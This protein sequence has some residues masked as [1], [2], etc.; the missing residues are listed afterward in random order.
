MNKMKGR[1]ASGILTASLLFAALV[2]TG[3]CGSIKAKAAPQ[4]NYKE[5][6]TNGIEGNGVTIHN[7]TWD[8]SEQC[9]V[10]NGDRSYIE[11]AN[12]LTKANANTGFS[13]EFEA[14]VSSAN[15]ADGTTFYRESGAT[16]S[17][18]GWQ[19]L[20]DL[21][22][23]T[24]N[25]YCFIN[26]GTSAPFR[27]AYTINGSAGEQRIDTPNGSAYY[28]AWH[29]Y[30]LVVAP[31][32][33]T[34]FYIDDNKVCSA[35]ANANT[36][37]VLNEL[38]SYNRCYIGTS[39]FEAINSNSDGFFIGKIK[40]FTFYP[41]TI[42]ATT[43][44]SG[45][46]LYT[47]AYEVNGGNRVQATSVSKLPNPLPTPTREDSQFLGWYTDKACTVEA[48]PGTELTK[49]T[50]L[51]AK[52]KINLS[53]KQDTTANYWPTYIIN[54][55]FEKQ[56]NMAGIGIPNGTDCGWNTTETVSNFFE[57]SNSGKSTYNPE[58]LT[59]G[60]NF[61]E[62]NPTHAVTLYQD[63]TTHGG[64]VIKWT[65]KHAPRTNLGG[66]PQQ[67]EVIIGNPKRNNGNIVYP[68][69][70][71]ANIQINVED[72]ATSKATYDY[73]NGK[74]IITGDAARANLQDLAALNLTEASGWKTAKGIY[75]V[76]TGQNV[77]RFAFIS[78]KPSGGAGNL[79]DDITFD[80]LIGNL[81]GVVDKSNG[82]VIIT[83]YWGETD[84]NKKLI[85][86]IG[87]DDIKEIDMSGI[88]SKSNKNFKLTIPKDM[89]GDASYINVYHEDYDCVKSTIYP[90]TV[91]KATKIAE[92]YVELRWKAAPGIASYKIDVALDANFTTFAEGYHDKSVTGTY[93][94]AEGLNNNT[95][96]YIRLRAIDNDGIPAVSS[97]TLEITTLAP[98]EEAQDVID[99]DDED[100]D[101]SSLPPEPKLPTGL[102]LPELTGRGT[103][104]GINRF[105]GEIDY[106]ER[107]K[108]KAYATDS[109]GAV[110][111]STYIDFYYETLVTDLDYDCYS[112]NNGKT[113]QRTNKPLSAKQM[114]SFINKR[115]TIKIAKGYNA[116]KHKP[117]ADAIVYSFKKIEKRYVLDTLKVNYTYFEDPYAVTQGQWALTDKNGKLVDLTRYEIGEM[118][119]K[120]NAIGEKGYGIWPETG[121]VWVNQVKNGK[122]FKTKYYYRLTSFET[123]PASK[124][125]KAIVS[126]QIKAPKIKV[127]YNSETIK[128]SKGMSIYFGEAIPDIT[129]VDPKK[130]TMEE[131]N[132]KLNYDLI[133]GGAVTLAKCTY[134]EI[135]GKG[136][137]NISEADAKTKFPLTNYI[138]T[139]RNNIY[140]W[141]TATKTKPASAIQKISLAKRFVVD[142]ETTLTVKNGKISKTKAI[143]NFTFFNESTGK[144]AS[145]IPNVKESTIIRARQKATAKGGKESD[146][147]Y[148]I[149][150]EAIL[151]IEYGVIDKKSK[152][153]GVISAVLRPMTNAERVKF[154]LAVSS[155]EP[156][157]EVTAE[158]D[159]DK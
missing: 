135:N 159:S 125:K 99:E 146:S 22:N 110:V 40:G 10:F 144:W 66:Y 70:V 67:M 68:T 24:T 27:I 132:A 57:W 139:T 115:S 91:P 157:E 43:T 134:D 44:K 74:G 63:L 147:T 23:G 45:E 14:Y 30:T 153:S 148:A 150:E 4:V 100:Y 152:K 136:M 154:G 105:L 126:S 80:T 15:N 9:A 87:A 65:L 59:D 1:K 107:H 53:I 94:K 69:G 82:S 34:T 109:D 38:S 32:G 83:G 117:N 7:V 77:T 84:T 96:Y 108:N 141:K 131:I 111:E 90:N 50:T 39:V 75:I 130:E 13:I 138:T 47:L 18:N 103:I 48:E 112:I 142:K 41:E 76:P 151:E 78:L 88:A 101:D 20:F 137:L 54:G 155:E 79:L 140:L 124:P 46:T 60:N 93:L 92:D 3:V 58:Y 29:K 98:G 106:R 85:V 89:I 104:P 71:D 37:T 102:P 120:G 133:S 118:K 19:R 156:A 55:D 73:D 36:I 145:G 5:F 6:L 33:Y 114:V 62:M 122:A 61:V 72:S 35:E 64:D 12:P 26:A 121:G 8:D 17:K 42:K 95:M 127:N 128:L 31:G 119:S 11:I 123:S 16:G 129:S 97:D 86:E 2:L 49:N 149:S 52:W 81:K 113:W 56:P 25:R 51:Y 116:K 21:S 158:A 28:N 143:K